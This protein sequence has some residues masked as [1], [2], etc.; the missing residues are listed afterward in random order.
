VQLDAS[1]GGAEHDLDLVII[2]PD[3]YR[4]SWLGAPTRAVIS[5]NDVQSV[6]REGLALR[7]ADTG[8]YA[9]ELVR[10]SA[11]VGPV[12]GSV[13]VVTGKQRHRIPFTLDGDRLR[14]ATLRI[15]LSERLVPLEGWPSR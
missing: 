7:G 5:A 11:T 3:G 8:Q 12:T 4:V 9:L 14:F 15:S 10:S 6:R 13:N 1:W 2:H